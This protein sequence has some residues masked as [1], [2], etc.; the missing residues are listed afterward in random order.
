MLGNPEEGGLLSAGC[1]RRLPN[2]SG[3]LKDYGRWMGI[4]WGGIYRQRT[5]MC[6]STEVKERVNDVKENVSGPE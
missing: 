3:F 6:K 2:Y 1:H 5:D 4:E